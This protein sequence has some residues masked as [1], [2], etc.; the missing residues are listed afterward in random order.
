[1]VRTLSTVSYINTLCEMSDFLKLN[2]II[3]ITLLVLV[4][5]IVTFSWVVYSLGKFYAYVHTI[6][7]ET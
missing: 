5:T 4:Q 1:M 6:Y 2:T 3:K 7:T